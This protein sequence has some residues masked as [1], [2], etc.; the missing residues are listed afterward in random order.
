MALLDYLSGGREPKSVEVPLFPLNTVLLPGSILA[1]KVFEQRYVEM[2]K[3]ASRITGP[4][5]YA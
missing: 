1:L 4:S 3:V 5:G 2:T